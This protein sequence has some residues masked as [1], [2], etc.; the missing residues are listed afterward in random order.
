[1]ATQLSLDRQ[2]RETLLGAY[3]HFIKADLL[4]ADKF[5]HDNALSRDEIT[6][7]FMLR[8]GYTKEKAEEEFFKLIHRTTE[9]RYRRESAL[10]RGIIS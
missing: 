9:A 2:E 3:L 8:F 10:R 5:R 1:M 6:K 7:A 4:Y